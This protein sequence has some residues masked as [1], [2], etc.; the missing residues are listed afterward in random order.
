MGV[1]RAPPTVG[2]R[3]G[4]SVSRHLNVS[5]ARN[6]VYNPRAK[7]PRLGPIGSTVMPEGKRVIPRFGLMRPRTLEEAFDAWDATGGD[8]AWYAGGTELLQVMKMGLATI[9]TLIDLKGV[10]ELRGIEQEVDGRLRIGAAST[11]REIERSPIVAHSLPS[12]A[13]LERHVANAR[14]RNTGTLG[15]NLA[16]GEPHSDPA[17]LL[18]A[19]DATVEL[20]SSDGERREPIAA[21]FLGPF[22]TT[23][24][25]EEIITAVRIPA[26]EPGEGRAYDKFAFFERPAVSVAVRV[27]TNGT[28]I[29]AADVVAGS[30]SDIPARVTGASDALVGVPTD[31]GTVDEALESAAARL[32]EE[33]DATDDINGSADYKRA[34]AAVLLRRVGRT[35]LEEAATRA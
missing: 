1:G 14:V 26:A 21:F 27:R 10:P 7:G 13:E 17:A 30:I 20:R 16:F 18:L 11:H 23:R 12:L 3:Y 22:A 29:V 32:Q 6:V 15:G 19:C 34:L 28:T 31:A 5:N 9:G 2:G 33:V 4:A 8:A 35:A 24:E 25:P